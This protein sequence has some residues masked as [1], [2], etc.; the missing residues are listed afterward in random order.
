VI[1]KLSLLTKISDFE[2]ISDEQLKT[3]CDIGLFMALEIL[4]FVIV[5][6]YDKA[7]NIWALS[8]TILGFCLFAGFPSWLDDM[9]D[10]IVAR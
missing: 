10:D 3:R 8:V 4:N 9:F 1:L 5:R 7:M 2:L 6:L